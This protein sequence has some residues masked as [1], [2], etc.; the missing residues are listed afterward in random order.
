MDEGK[1][2]NDIINE[3]GEKQWADLSSYI[4]TYEQSGI[5]NVDLLK[6]NEHN[7]SPIDVLIEK[8]ELK[9]LVKR[10][11]KEKHE[12]TDL[13]KLIYHEG[14]WLK[15]IESQNQTKAKGERISNLELESLQLSIDS[16]KTQVRNNNWILIVLAFL[17]SLAGN[18]IANNFKEIL[19]LL[20]IIAP[21]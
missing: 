15:Y 13:G 16:L 3:L 17:A 5:I 4:S 12:L 2:T 8:I 11:T 10:V 7:V 18:I 20:G 21:E 9:K 14:G 1:L 19:I 6:V